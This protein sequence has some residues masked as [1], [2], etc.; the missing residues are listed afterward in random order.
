MQ[1]DP[2]ALAPTSEGERPTSAHTLTAGGEH[3]VSAPVEPSPPKSRRV[4]PPKESK[5]YKVAV[6]VIAMRAQGVLPKA[7][8]DQLGYS[9]ETIRKYLYRAYQRG[10]IASTDLD[11]PED[12][13]ELI[14]SAVVGNVETTLKERTENG[15]LTKSAKEMTVEAAKGLGLFK[16][17]QVVKGDVGGAIGV[18]LRVDVVMPPNARQQSQ[19]SIRPGTVGGAAGLDIPI[20]AEVIDSTSE[21]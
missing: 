9:E 8:A 13:L 7:I 3:R 4:R 15:A 11:E 19:I 16:T 18:A 17:H 20:D 6:A 1:P 21:G 5:V 10:W 12:R 14:K 2:S